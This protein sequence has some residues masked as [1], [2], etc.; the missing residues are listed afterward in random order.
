MPIT[1]FDLVKADMDRAMGHLRDELARAYFQ[2]S[3]FYDQFKRTYVPPTR[4]QKLQRKLAQ[5]KGYFLT[6]GQ[7]L[8]GDD[9]QP[10][11]DDDA[12]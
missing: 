7:A 4:L 12:W 8:R 3:P 2:P 11:S 5:V 1:A 10:P 6:L 9:L